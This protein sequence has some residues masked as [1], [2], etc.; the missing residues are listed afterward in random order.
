LNPTNCAPMSVRGVIGGS[1]GGTAPVSDRFQVGSCGDLAFR[2]RLALRL[3]GKVGRRAH[4]RLRAA[5]RMPRGDSNIRRVAVTLPRATILDQGNIRTV[6]TRAQFAARR[7]P[8]ASVYGSA[9]AH[10]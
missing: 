4:P 5:L 10:T 1:A 7:C 8:A 6:C 9:V 2:P 3:F